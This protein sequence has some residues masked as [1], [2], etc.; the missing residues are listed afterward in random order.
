MPVI[1]KALKPKES[2]FEPQNLGEHIHR[3]RLLRQLNQKEAACQ[4]GVKSWTVLNWE[5]GHTEPPIESMPAI[6]QFLG[7]DPYPKPKT[8]SERMFAKR[9]AMGWSILEAAWQLGVEQGTW[10][11][12]ERGET[13]LLRRHRALVAR[14]LEL[15]AEEIQREMR[16]RW[17]R[18]HARTPG[19]KT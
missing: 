2:D 16:D 12:W 15:A 8:L 1:L 14:F 19:K 7:Y 18:S 9:R 13:I 5:K 3:C 6:L 11:A 17:N 10:G 4:L